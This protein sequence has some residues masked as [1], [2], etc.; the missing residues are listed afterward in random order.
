MRT[1]VSLAVMFVV[2]LA[3][4]AVPGWLYEVREDRPLQA[5]GTTAPTLPPSTGGSPREPLATL[6]SGLGESLTAAQQALAAHEQTRA[7]Q[8]MDAAL[9]AARVGE[10]ASQEAFSPVLHHIQHARKEFQNGRPADAR[11]TLT[12]ARAALDSARGVTGAEKSPHQLAR[13]VGGTLINAEGVVVGEVAAVSGNEV[14]LVLG[15]G[16]D[17]LGFI[18]LGGGRHVTVPAD[19]LVFGPDPFFGLTLIAAPLL[20]S[21]GPGP[22]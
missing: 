14:E 13:Y 12:E 18:D 21:D 4:L 1:A 16:R 6:A 3:A 5:P 8:A 7:A 15:G 2:G 19:T 9:R 11:H 10:Q 20:P 22:R 17:F